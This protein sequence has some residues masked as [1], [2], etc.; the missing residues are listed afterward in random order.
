M[1][2]RIKL[3]LPSRA[4]FVL[5][6][7]LVVLSA[8]AQTVYQ[9]NTTTT[10]S[11]WNS[12]ANWTPSSGPGT[13]VPGS[14]DTAAFTNLDITAD[15]TVTLDANQSVNKLIFGDLATA[16]AGSWIVSTGA[17][18]TATLT[19]G[20]TAPQIMVNPLGTGKIAQINATVAGTAGLTV[21]GPGQLQLT[22][23]NTVTGG[24]LIDGATLALG[25]A[26]TVVGQAGANSV[27]TLTNGGTLTMNGFNYNGAN[28]YATFTNAILVPAG[29]TGNV[30]AVGRGTYSSSVTVHGTLNLTTSY[31][32]SSPSGDWS[33]S[34]GQINV[35]GASAGGDIYLTTTGNFNF[36]TAA[37]YFGTGVG[38]LYTSGNNG[39]NINFSIGELA[40]TNTA[41]AIS[42]GNAVAT[43]PVRPTTFVV[44]ARNT[45]ATYAGLIKDNNRPANI[46]KVGTGAWILPNNNNYTG[47]TLVATGAIYGVTGGSISN[48]IITV[49]T[50]T[51]YGAATFGV[52][53]A[54]TGGKWVGTN[55]VLRSGTALAFNYG[56]VIPSTTVAP[57]QLLGGITATNP[58]SL[59]VLGGSGWAAGGVYPLAKYTTAFVGGGFSAF[60]LGTL[61]LRV[62]GVLS[63]DTA[64]SQID[65]VVS[66]VNEPVKWATGSAPWDI[67]A[68]SNWK[69]AVGTSTTYQEQLGLGD[70]V[71]F[72][73]TQS[74]ASPI[75][76]T[77]NTNVSPASVTF[78]N[79]T[80]N[81][82]L[83][84]SSNILGT[85]SLTKTGAGILT[86]QN[87]NFY[88]GGTYC[89]G[90][91]LNFSSLNNLGTGGINFTGGTLQFAAGNTTDISART[92]WLGA[93][94]GTIDTAANNLTFANR[95]GNNG[96]GSL[97]K[98]GTGTLTLNTN[99]TYTGLTSVSQGALI[100]GAGA[101]LSNS[102]AIVVNAGATLNASATGFGFNLNG[103]NSQVLA[104][105]G[106][107][108]G[109]VTSVSG[110]QITPGTNGVTG[111]LKFGNDLNLN[112]GTYVFDVATTAHDLLV[113]QGQLNITG[114]T[115]VVNPLT[116]LPNG[117]YKLIQCANYGGGVS[118]L[119]LSGGLPNKIFTLSDA[120]SGEIDLVVTGSATNSLV[121]IGDGGASNYWDV[122]NSTN[123]LDTALAAAGVIFENG[124]TVTFNDAYSLTGS[125]SPA[126][127]IA[128]GPVSPAAVVVTTTNTYTFIGSKIT[129][130]GTSLTKNGNGTLVLANAGNDFGGTT[131]INNGVLQV[132]DGST[133][134]TS[135][136]IGNVTDNGALVFYQPDNSTVFGNISGAGSLYQ[137]G[138]NAGATLT[139]LGNNTYSG[140]TTVDTGVLQ[141]GTGGT[142]GNLGSSA[143][144][145][146][147]AGTLLINR[148]GTYSL[149]NGITGNG[150]LTLIGPATVTLAGVNNYLNNTTVASGVLK[151]GGNN[152][153]PSGGLTTGWLVLD[154]G[155]TAA[156]T[157]DLNGYNQAVNELSGLTGTVLGQIVNNGGS[158]LN[159]LT[160]GTTLASTTYGGLIANNNNAG[161][162]QIGLNIVGDGSL[163]YALTL[164]GANNFSGPVK[165]DG[166]KV[167][168]GGALATVGD[169]AIGS[170][171]ITLTNNGTLQMNG[172]GVVNPTT[173]FANSITVPAG[174]TGNLLTGG[175]TIY[176]GNLIVHGTLNLTTSYA[177]SEPAGDWSASDGQINII[178][179][180]GG[181]T[182]YWFNGG[183]WS[184]GTAAVDLGT[185]VYFQNAGNTG[186]GGNTITIGEL[187]GTGTITDTSPTGG[188][189]RITTYIIGGRNSNA[190]FAGTIQN[191]NRQTA[192][193]KV[194]TGSWTL[195]GT[196]TATA[197]TTVS[198]GS[199]IIGTT[200]SF[201]SNSTNITVAAGALFDVSIYNGLTL[202]P[203]QT[204]AGSGVVTGAVTMV[205]SDIL[206]PGSSAA[207]G[208]L[209]FSN[210][211]TLT[212]TGVN[213]TSIF[214][215]SS[216]PTGVS[217]ANSQIIVAGDLTLTGTNIVVINPLNSLLGAGTY[218]LFKYSGNL[219][220]ES[221]VVA[222]GTT[223]ENNFVAA[224]AFAANSDVSF[225]FS[226]APGAVVLLV[227][228]TGQNLVWQGGITGTVTNN[229]DVN[230]SSNWL[231]GA[232]VTNFLTYDKVVFDDSSTNWNPILAGT[233]APGSISV[234]STN[235]YTFSGTGKLTGNTAITKAG[236]NVLIISNT[237]GND[238][239]GG[240]AVTAGTLQLGVASALGATNS[241]TTVASGATLDIHGTQPVPQTIVAQGAGV[242]GN[243][244][245]INNG[246][247]L[248]NQ[249]FTGNI[250][251]AGDTTVG[252]F[253]RWDLYN[254]TLTGNN[255]NLTKVGTNYIVLNG[256]GDIGVSNLNVQSGY[257]T[258]IGNTTLGAS[259]TVTIGSGA[260]IDLYATSVTNTKPVAMTS[261]TLS[262]SSGT[263]TYGGP[264][265]LNQTETF[266]A[267][268]PLVLNGVLAGAGGLLKNGA[269]QLTMNAPCTYT[270][271]TTIS[272][273][274]LALVG[275]AGFAAS[276]SVNITAAAQL[277]VT[278]LTAPA[279]TVVSGQNLK[280]AGAIKGNLI[281]AAGSTLI[282]GDI[283]PGTLTVSNSATLDGNTVMNLNNTGTSSKLVAATIAFG[284]TLTLT[285]VGP[286]LS[287][288]NSFP[289]FSA[290]SY[291]GSFTAI[292]PAKPD[293][294]SALAWDTSALATSGTLKVVRGMATNPTN[295][296]FS[297]SGTT[298]TLSWPA[299]HLGW[300]LEVQT[301]NLSAGISLNTNDWM[302]V[303]GSTGINQ[304]N[305]TLDPTKPTEF[306]R[307]VNP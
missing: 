281:T 212:N 138:A 191:L 171:A 245:L 8:G 204:L 165:I 246:A 82:V 286:A 35:T 283:T 184:L 81:Y 100:L 38:T 20:G 167:I 18:T 226:N 179:G 231:A 290:A 56:T 79:T 255:H 117:T 229:W 289:L 211:L 143:V 78:S 13:S 194:G 197:Q 60:S 293:N 299:D 297:V 41:C 25:G 276:A 42:G 185:G 224:G 303:T 45:T 69:D 23:P 101:S 127:N 192:I 178:A 269:S 166:A 262:S 40:S 84:G 227:K 114:G 151:L 210:N 64:N 263:N 66:A 132:G 12:A 83:T 152:V 254:G 52:Q 190:T 55:L 39:G 280:G 80:K 116:T 21:K 275:T 96:P 85:T 265:T 76:I 160:I 97:T 58:V 137:W 306:Y 272:N 75:T 209:S 62:V 57:L 230:V 6:A 235:S 215:L 279:W 201:M 203:G 292:V 172:L 298:L 241:T 198:A 99:S 102:A 199:L 74:G 222:P 163:S 157:L 234:N 196:D 93:G 61:P 2:T 307:L 134:G 228:P 217:K 175:R 88:S 44:G 7:C 256:L 266:T 27:I 4:L 159:T 24:L 271:N 207:A 140:R 15:T 43:S 193:N 195:T 130:G 295:I 221:G 220:N 19:L 180:I 288:G 182:V 300:A 206:L 150:A 147:N 121:W 236:T 47:P 260:R 219:I 107:V 135:L 155:A 261:A 95:I 128:N 123:W 36:G 77:L 242:G 54:A 29:T 223:L 63:N 53:V 89:G 274:V 251:L 115:L 131:A 9:W 144:V 168:L 244:A 91:V 31:V 37:I 111:T 173:T 247:Q 161:S 110:A 90:G 248:V 16:T 183:N 285:N 3:T 124:D 296:T 213:V 287:V 200:S 46:T 291:S 240:V 232:V 59:N 252:G 34:D 304:T 278:A 14:N 11:S 237:G 126:V 186:T 122:E 305:L 87:N 294:N 30:N 243:G 17:L 301:N 302:R 238:Y 146:T 112:G 188:T 129:G 28:T 153:L 264:I 105:N 86:L 119:T 32:R 70:Q 258:L 249:G 158:G 71:V 205:D 109:V 202:S 218:T 136:G 92:V 187:T 33:G 1:N 225:T 48:S 141:I 181:G 257:F 120:T 103:L 73:D 259:G 50:N 176:S 94:G 68:S 214:A 106:T 156:G 268:A 145:L 49:A 67:S 133:A 148:S 267:T 125:E 177:R 270:G 277:D 65:L 113:V 98:T 282:P 189:N 104:G 170:G 22:T 216:D 250:T 5:M 284:G 239:S 162:G 51:T 208:T 253:N 108:T 164:S 142:S 149:A 118:S 273:G 154:G 139:L 26:N 72:E 10:P 174:T 233:L 169:A